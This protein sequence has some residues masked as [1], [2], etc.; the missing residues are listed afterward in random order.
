MIPIAVNKTLRHCSIFALGLLLFSQNCLAQ[1]TL[2]W[3]HTYGGIGYE[4]MGASI[5]TNDGGYLFGGI[6]TS[7]TP[8]FEVSSNTKDTVDFPELTGD[9]WLVKTDGD[10]NVEWDKRYGGYYEDRLWSIVPTQDGGYLLGGESRSGIGAD[11]TWA[12]RG[13]R[14]FWV[15]K[16][17]A[18]GNRQ[19]DRAY[20]GTGDEELRK[21]VPLPNGQFWLAGFSN[22]P[23]SFEK[24]TG[25]FNGSYDFWSVKIDE[26]GVP[27]G[28]FTFGGDGKDRL[29]DALLTTDGNLLLGGPTES[30]PSF[31]KTA[32]FYGLNDNWVVKCT[33]SGIILWEAAFGGDKEDVL[34]RLNKSKDG[35]YFAIG[36]STS[37]KF[38]GNKTADH[39]G[40]DDIWLVKFEDTGSGANMLWDKAYGGTS[41]D[42]GFDI[43][44][45]TVGNLLIIGESSSVPDGVQ[46]T[47]PV[48]GSKDYWF[49]YADKNGTALWD[50]TLGGS[51]N[52]NGRFVLQAHDYGLIITGI[53]SS[54]NYAP[55]KSEDARGN[56]TNDIFVIR[57][58]CSF[59]GPSLI[60]PPKTCQNEVIHLDATVPIPCIGCNYVW[61]DGETGPF[62]S[63]T[64]DSTLEL[65]VTVVHPDGCELSDST[66]LV[67]VPGP[68]NL[69]VAI[70]PISCFGKND[71]A[72]LM[73]SVD[74][75]APPF[76]FSFDGGP[77]EPTANYLNLA[78]GL[79]DLSIID[80]NGCKLDSTFNIPE[81]EEVLV[82]LGPDIYLNYGD[83]VQLQALTN[84]VDSFTF[85]WGQPKL[86]SCT[87]CLEP[88]VVGLDNTTTFNI[89]LKD[90]DGC[91]AEDLMRIILQKSD[92]VFI[93]NSFSPNLDNTNDFFTVYAD[94]KVSKINSLK[95]FDRWGE[96]MFERSDF[97]PN[98]E[99][100]GWDGKLDGR[101]LD[102]AVFIYRAEL[103][104]FDGRTEIYMGDVTLMK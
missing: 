95:V 55:Y 52:D 27:L 92:N 91:K 56:S 30:Q 82:E 35:N 31:T 70:D 25:A 14:D 15:V 62:R 45:S 23:A 28:D 59:P 94:R 73:E 42:Q 44:E 11:R 16:I 65:K 10:G 20:G 50:E 84:L 64:P 63:L 5:L 81:K 101:P 4:E 32:P 97:P 79:Y 96:L 1:L 72:F 89:I 68:E 93:P 9:Y 37:D 99:S 19:W 76:Q 57:T 36:Q 85:E 69:K 13:L 39:Y 104:F 100:L 53:S 8:A 90:K 87:D 34:Q 43:V 46:K 41:S 22:S 33:P 83:S 2:E 18:N 98:K 61:E 88:W 40:S 47:A 24:S 74:G 12:N 7:R 78:P 66:T 17:D 29:F 6:T 54:D 3:N 51:S 67:I 60:A 80:T 102:P 86:L 75:V 21:I 48:L 49:V 26:N 38:S 58:G 71:A 77:W 103:T